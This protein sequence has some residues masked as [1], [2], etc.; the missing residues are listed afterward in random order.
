MRDQ[1]DQQCHRAFWVTMK[2]HHA[3]TPQ[4]GHILDANS[5]QVIYSYLNPRNLKKEYFY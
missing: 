1:I 3:L 5:I 4:P 2:K